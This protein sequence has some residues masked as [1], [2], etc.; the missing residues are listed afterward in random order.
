V[1]V[2]IFLS[3]IPLLDLFYPGLPKTH[4]GQDHVAR[5]ANFYLNLTYGNIIPRWAPNLNWGYGHPI[6]MFLY[7]FPSYFASFF[8]VLGFSFVDSVKLVFGVTFILS[9]LSMYL[10]MSSFTNRFAGFASAVVYMFAPYRFVDLYVRGAIG[11][12]V[13]F[14]FPPLILYFLYRISKHQSPWNVLLGALS[15]SGLILSHN[16]ISLMFLPIILLF[17]IY[18]LLQTKEKWRV[19]VFQ[20]ILMLGFGFLVSAFFWI[21]AFVEGKYTLRDIVTENEY[22]NRFEP[23]SHFLYSPWSYGG[24]GLLSVQIGLVQWAVVL[25]QPILLFRFYKKN[26]YIFGLALSL[27]IL[28]WITIFLMMDIS[29]PVYQIVTT[30]QKFQFPW[31]FLT[32]TVFFTSVISGLFVLSLPKKTQFTIALLL[33]GLLLFVNRNYWQA[34][35]YLTY[36]ES[37]YTG[38]YNGTTDTGESA[39]IWSVRFMLERPDEVI[40]VI[41]GD[42]TITEVMRTSTSRKYIID[43]NERTRIRENTLYFPGWNVYVNGSSSE[44]EFQDQLNRGLITYFVPKGINDVT[45]IFENTKLRFFAEVLSLGGLVG[46]GVYFFIFKKIILW[47]HFQ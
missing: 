10:F 11:E 23:F 32:L 18:V 6:L 13:A 1:I 42:A 25:L 28:F 29:I 45:I 38:I 19:I 8:H 35:E 14:I 24:T 31:R 12:H 30:L 15:F 5:I 44:I 47:R 7:P 3:L 2:L 33:A 43:A 36:P 37:F 34:N 21:P 20:S 46:L 22:L 27:F 39:P 26:T 17:V 41:E 16:A 9:G 4:D 40:E